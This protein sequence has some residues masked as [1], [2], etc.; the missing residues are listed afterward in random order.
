MGETRVDLLHLLEDLRDAYPGSIEETILSE[1]L[2]NALD[3]G[4]DAVSLAAEPGVAALTVVDN[5]RG[6][7]RREL[8]RYHDL[9][10]TTKQ[11][12]RGIGFAGVGIKLGL[13]A[14]Q[15]VITE[16]VSGGKRVASAWHLRSRNRAPWRWVEPPGLVAE[17]GT[18]VRLVLTNPLSP[19]LDAGFI[20][21]AIRRHFH[22]LLDPE[23]DAILGSIYPRGVRLTVNGRVL[24]R[25][26]PSADRVSVAVRLP[27]RRKPSALGYLVR[28]SQDLAEDQAGVAIST[29]GKVIKR[30]WDW[31]GVTPMAPERLS[32][33]IE[34]PALA[35]CLT[36][37][38]ADFIR[39]GQRGAIYLA[40]RKAIQEVVAERLAAWG[41]LR[42]AEP[43][44]R[45]ARPIERDLETVL[46]DLAEDFP[47]LSALVDARPGGQR[48]L[49]LGGSG[50]TAEPQLIPVLP[51][52]DGSERSMEE[53]VDAVAEPPPA[54]AY[55]S[56]EP[57]APQAAVAEAALGRG[58]RKRPA[59]Y[60][61]RLQ[62]ESRPDEG[63]L[64][65]LVESTVW[66]NDA[67]PAYRRA[68]AS[69]SEGYHLALAVALALAPLAVEPAQ[70]QVFVETFLTKWGEAAGRT[71]KRRRYARP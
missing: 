60:G 68:V 10:A 7:K 36:L 5:G 62:F 57:P 30:G 69:R 9:A 65:R 15:E 8:G 13:L 59:R 70:A 66:V 61:L 35:E 38:K 50:A 11:R 26:G 51:P 27:R 12:G 32:G 14:C 40:F 63:A 47:L 49:P 17:H 39:A 34:A 55:Q 29:L 43:R 1:T 16:T 46:V 44:R 20:E 56:S 48:R 18:A 3:S 2:A 24:E 19:L 31:L 22:T 45:S 53:P 41:D 58:G 52:S 4:A 54:E 67:H 25:A 64:S 33:V 28:V 6:M 42:E 21:G 37:N 71:K 23:F